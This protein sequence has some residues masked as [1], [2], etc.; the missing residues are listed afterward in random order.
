MNQTY[1]TIRLASSIAEIEQCY[2]VMAQLQLNLQAD[3]FMQQVQLQMAIGYQLAYIQDPEVV[4][5]AGFK[6]DFSLSWGKY[7]YVADLVV[8]KQMRSQL[9]EI[10]II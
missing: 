3:Q 8:E 2:P 9:I 1:K 10:N 4:G 5:V 6:I 7:L